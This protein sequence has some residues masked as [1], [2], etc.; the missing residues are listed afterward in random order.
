MIAKTLLI[1]RDSA[2]SPYTLHSYYSQFIRPSSPPPLSFTHFYAKLPAV[3]TVQVH[4]TLLADRPWTP[5]PA[6]ILHQN[7][8]SYYLSGLVLTHQPAQL[9][10]YYLGK[11][12]F[13]CCDM[14]VAMAV[15]V[16]GRLWNGETV[17]HFWH[18]GG[19]FHA[20]KAIL[21]GGEN[22]SA[23]T[24][25]WDQSHLTM[26]RQNDQLIL[27]DGFEELD[28]Y[29]WPPITVPLWPLA[30]E[31]VREG[32]HCMQLIAALLAEIEARGYTP[33]DLLPLLNGLGDKPYP[34]AGDIPLRL[35][36]I[37]RE[38]TCRTN[39]AADLAECHL[40]ARDGSPLP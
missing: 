18:L 16:D 38:L 9:L 19:W 20:L 37:V 10:D 27:F 34:A 1:I 13:T 17:D 22:S 2:V 28:R 23:T 35:A 36:V 30:A 6:A 3:T 25:V 4:L 12:D 33:A 29:A 32:E 5:P 7:E 39:L 11:A 24:S 15:M 14:G 8:Y 31:L 21:A 40:L 26:R